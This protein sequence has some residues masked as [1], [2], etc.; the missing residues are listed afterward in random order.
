MNLYQR[1]GPVL[2]T[3]GAGYIG[4]MLTRALLADGV[5]V[6]VLDRRLFG[7]GLAAVTDP[8]LENVLGDIRDVDQYRAALDGVGVVVHLAAVAN[9]PSFDL[10]PEVGRSVNFDCLDH[11]FRLAEQHGVRRFVY[12]SS[13]SVYGIS[14]APEV[15]EGHPLV[16]ITDYNRYKAAG[17]DLLF[18]LT[19]PGFETVAVRA[20]T[21]CGYSTRQRLDLTVNMLTA[22]AVRAREITVFGG[23][24]Y[25]PN[26]HL[27]DL[28]AVYRRLV[29]DASLGVLDGKPLNVGHQNLPVAEIAELIAAEVTTLTGNAI[30]TT[31]TPS[32]DQR[33]YRLTS[34]R[35]A[36]TLGI[37]PRLT[38]ADACAE[39]AS[40]IIK[41]KLPDA[42]TNPRY[43][44]VR[45]MRQ[46][47][48][49]PHPVPR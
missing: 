44:N 13:A 5:P 47:G 20:A 46:W 15:D 29:L 30:T 16:P 3:G 11:V 1:R 14:D 40:A 9:D 31:T 26:V 35:L 49:E 8:L 32:D 18:P 43:Y 10:D 21:V 19:R 39:V 34:S 2:I 41:G 22:Q 36:E 28:V 27:R 42:L 25:R 23:A 12:A 48:A 7:D 24:Q 45:W 4:S 33:S 37:T 17:E 6:R 38:V